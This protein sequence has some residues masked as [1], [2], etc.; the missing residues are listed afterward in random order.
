MNIVVLDGLTR[1][2]HY[3]D[4]S[5]FAQFGNL[6]VYDRTP[7][8]LI[9][10]RASD[11]E[12]VLINGTIL[13]RE[14]LQQ[15]PRLKYI[16]LL[17][18]GFDLVDVRAA[19]EQGI[20]VTHVSDYA[21][22]SVAQMAFAHLL[23]LT[24]R[25]DTIS[26]NCRNDRYTECV[27]ML[28]NGEPLIELHGM[29]MGIVGFGRIGQAM[30]KFSMAFGMDILAHDPFRKDPSPGVNFVELDTL[31]KQ[32]NVVSLHCPLS[33]ANRGLVDRRRLALM[34]PDAFVINTSRGALIDE[35]ALADALNSGRIAGAGLDVLSVEPPPKDHPLLS[36]KNCV[37]TPHIGSATRAAWDRE[38]QIAIDNL[39]AF[40]R[41]EPQNV[42]L[43]QGSL[44]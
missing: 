44:G 14:T 35:A 29:K 23:N 20:V 21:T 25:I 6:K 8:E 15:L 18:T 42:V 33:D 10:E 16:G 36:A 3:I 34:K 4:W 7:T 37:V 24:Q 5:P 11:A 17:I 41:G 22:L 19:V 12:I 40:L 32:S 26:H 2:S 38:I 39:K 30:A 13:E 1:F 27:N 28:F 9:A 43:P 31:F